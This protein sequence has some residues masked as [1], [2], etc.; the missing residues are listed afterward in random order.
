MLA[1]KAARELL[2]SDSIGRAVWPVR[3]RPLKKPNPKLGGWNKKNYE[4]G[5]AV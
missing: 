5:Y 4:A 1:S 3:S 2:E